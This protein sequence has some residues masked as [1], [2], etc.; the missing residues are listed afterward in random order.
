M[1]G[2]GIEVVPNIPKCWGA[3]I[4]IVPNLPECRVPVS[5]SY[6]T[7]PECLVGYVLAAVPSTLARFGRAFT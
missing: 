7:L 3:G 6:R 2:T 4:E 5:S 1:S